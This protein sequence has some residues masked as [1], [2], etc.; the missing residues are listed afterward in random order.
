LPARGR[1]LL[2]N[3]LQKQEAKEVKSASRL[4]LRAPIRGADEQ[5]NNPGIAE[6]RCRHL[7][8][9]PL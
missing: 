7:A 1:V 4:A 8:N 2:A 6:P 9:M 3:H 5:E